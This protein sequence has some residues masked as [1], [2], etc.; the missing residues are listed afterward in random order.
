MGAELISIIAKA[1]GAFKEKRGPI[2]SLPSAPFFNESTGLDVLSTEQK[3]CRTGQAGNLRLG[4]AIILNKS[5]RSALPKG[6][7]S[8]S[9]ALATGIH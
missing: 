4:L 6:S 1:I 7:R 2:S 3:L 5:S 8:I 9:A